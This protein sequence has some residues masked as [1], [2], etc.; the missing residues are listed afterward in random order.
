MRHEEGEKGTSSE[1]KKKEVINILIY[2]IKQNQNVYL[3][4]GLGQIL[5][6]DSKLL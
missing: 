5:T 1:E 4:A 6:S 2:M 3:D